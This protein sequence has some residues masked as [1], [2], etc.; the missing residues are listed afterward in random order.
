MGR[1]L[2]RSNLRTFDYETEAIVGNPVW[3]PPRP[4]GV[5]LKRDGDGSEYL[6]WGHPTGNNC[7]FED[8]RKKFLSFL[9]EDPDWLAHN[10]PFE[11]AINRKYFGV[12]KRNPERFH[13]TQYLIFLADPYAPSFSLKPSAQ[14]ILGMD[15]DEQDEL[16]EWILRNVPQAKASD[17]G[18]YISLA[19]GDLV[20]KYAGNSAKTGAPGDTDR[21][22]LLYQKLWPEIEAAG[23]AEAYR[24][25]Q[26]LMPVLSESSRRGVRI[27]EGRLERDLGIFR[28]AQA[29]CDAYIERVIGVPG[30]CT[31]AQLADALDRSG[32][33][34]EWVLTPTGKRS[35]ARKNLLGRVRDPALLQ[36]LGYRGVLE[37][38]LGTFAE[39]WLAQARSEGGRVHPSWNQVRGDRGTDG[40]LSGTRTGRMSCARP[41][42]QNPPNDFEGLA[43]PEDVLALLVRARETHRDATIPDVIHMR[44]YLLPEPGHVWAKRDFSAQEMRIL[45]HF[46][47]GRL[48][49][50]FKQDPKTD[51]HVAVQK[52]ILENTGI[53]LSRKYTKITGFGIMYGRGVDNL[54]VALGVDRAQAQNTR[55]AYY[56]ALPEVRWLADQT[57][58]LGRTGQAIVTWGGRKY[59]REPDPA[60][61]LSYKLLNYLIQGSAADQTKQS[62][63]D[64]HANK[65]PDDMLIA[66][67]HDEINVSMPADDWQAG[68]S[69]LREQMNADRFD[70][71]FLSEGYVGP[72][73]ADIKGCD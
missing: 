37:T 32:Q 16:R 67:V 50:A 6:A 62:M 39:P 23:M 5:S 18:A 28:Q 10:A 58:K 49:E 59:Y 11:D 43:V 24:R 64:W 34:T 45:A 19:P 17:W 56:T 48:F 22:Y 38:C 15:P 65:R 21:T 2:W 70:V 47:E 41:N 20:G 55:D 31:D 27:D 66:A 14:R 36:Y 26:L 33:I 4:V 8:A 3:N 40:D 1:L 13:D 30:S 9:R 68:M 71:P 63:I 61:D 44:Q 69:I 29:L 53:N 35:V 25:E 57:R 60:R 42:L 73:W 54:G 7:T 72:N 51:P 52:I 12:I 46:A